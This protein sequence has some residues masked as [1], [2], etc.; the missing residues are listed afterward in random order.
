MTI[1]LN[2]INLWSENAFFKWGRIDKVLFQMLRDE[3]KSLDNIHTRHWYEKTRQMDCYR[4]INAL[5]RCNPLPCLQCGKHCKNNVTTNSTFIKNRHIMSIHVTQKINAD[6]K[7]HTMYNNK[8]TDCLL[9]YCLNHKVETLYTKSWFVM[10]KGEAL[11]CWE[12]KV[13]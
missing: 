11:Y 6:N 10:T 8:M 9:L 12:R 13:T 3:Q 1:L 5:I 7:P 4:V 2:W